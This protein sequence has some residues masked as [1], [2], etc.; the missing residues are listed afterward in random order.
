MQRRGS[1][2][3]E[4]VAGSYMS[5]ESCKEWGDRHS[6]IQSVHKLYSN[7]KGGEHDPYLIIDLHSGG[8]KEPYISCESA[9]ENKINRGF[10]NIK[11]CPIC[12]ESLIH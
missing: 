7:V 10:I 4:K 11:F 8:E 12:G 2:H 3:F 6:I 5:C 1:R 9:S